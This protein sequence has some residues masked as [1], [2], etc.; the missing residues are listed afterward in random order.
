MYP[1]SRKKRTFF[2]PGT[3]AEAERGKKRREDTPD[4][5]EVCLSMSSFLS[6]FFTFS[7]YTNFTLLSFFLFPSCDPWT[8]ISLISTPYHFILSCD[9][10]IPLFEKTLIQASYSFS[11][12]P[13]VYYTISFISSLVY[14]P[15]IFNV[16]IFTFVF[17]FA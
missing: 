10:S 13:C 11:A 7:H 3:T 4:D 16:P 12:V 6:F 14:L 8:S 1:R 17:N 2:S 5:S 9:I 15:F